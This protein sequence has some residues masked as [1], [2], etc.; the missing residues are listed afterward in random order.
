MQQV[1]LCM[2]P[3]VGVNQQWR[4]NGTEEGGWRRGR[5]ETATDGGNME[6][7]LACNVNSLLRETYKRTQIWSLRG[8]E[9]KKSREMRK[10]Q[11]RVCQRTR[12][13]Q[14]KD[15]ETKVFLTRIA[16]KTVEL[17]PSATSN[18]PLSLGRVKLLSRPEPNILRT[19][20]HKKREMRAL[21][22][23]RQLRFKAG[24]AR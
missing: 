9:D 20:K 3:P 24:T 21:L 10:R 4:I 19:N 6:R 12:G 22:F 14:R 8:R 16:L 17:M 5:T 2:K 15:D 13:R 23:R 11:H 1:D 7:Y 18:S